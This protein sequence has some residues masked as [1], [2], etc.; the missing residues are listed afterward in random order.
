MKAEE[1]GD[2]DILRKT[3]WCLKFKMLFIFEKERQGPHME[4]LTL[5]CSP[6]NIPPLME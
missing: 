1:E 2:K 4:E 5:L 3:T 6:T